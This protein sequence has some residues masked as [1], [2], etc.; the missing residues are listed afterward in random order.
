MKVWIQRFLLGLALAAHGG[1]V[2]GAG[3]TFITIASGR[4]HGSYYNVARAICDRIN[5]R[6]QEHGIRCSVA[7]SDG[8]I[9]NIA[10]IRSG[11]Y[12]LG[13]VQSDIQFYAVKGT[14]MFEDHPPFG[15][16]RALFSLHPE[17]FTVIVHPDQGI[18]SLSGL[19]GKRIDMGKAGS[20][21]RW[22]AETVL[23]ASGV[24]RKDLGEVVAMNLLE[25]V[26]AFCDS[27]L[28]ALLL[29]VG[30]PSQS[31][32]ETLDL[33]PGGFLA[34]TREVVEKLVARYPYFIRAEIPGGIYGGNP[35]PLETVG[36]RATLVTAEKLPGRI[37]YEVVKSV[38]GDFETFRRSAAVLAPLDRRRMVVESLTAPLHEGAVKFYRQAGLLPSPPP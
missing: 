1:G 17:A 37:A 12:E 7:Y 14:G 36:V 9:A 20:G 38:F 32:R 28:D 13:I 8:S 23:R 27:R 34:P 26:A 6:R 18:R 19:R 33:C 30:H 3:P 25:Q 29:V 16:L 11:E 15:E 4:V 10:S 35:E 2:F 24:G 22:V 21:S 31:I 5:L